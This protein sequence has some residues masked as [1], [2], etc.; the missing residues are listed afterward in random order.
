[1]KGDSS[2]STE[3]LRTEI[4]NYQIHLEYEIGVL[5]AK[6]KNGEK[7]KKKRKRNK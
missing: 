7:R 5:T 6:I 1:M 4:Y 2:P 3:N